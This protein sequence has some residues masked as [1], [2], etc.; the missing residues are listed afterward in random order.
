MK[1][2]KHGEIL[3]VSKGAFKASF[4]KDGWTELGKESSD[5]ETHAKNNESA[6]DMSEVPF[7]QI[8]QSAE[9]EPEDIEEEFEEEE[10]LETPIS[11][12][13]VT[14]LVEFAEEHDIDISGIKGKENI[15]QA[16]LASLEE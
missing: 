1:I 6:P 13:T 4:E 2:T 9:E 8:N 14:E 7:A 11:E 3:N 5:V 12:M 16:I 15:K 10:E